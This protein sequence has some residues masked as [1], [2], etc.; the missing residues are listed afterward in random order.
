[1][2]RVVAGLHGTMRRVFGRSF[3]WTAQT[4]DMP[5]IGA[6]TVFRRGDRMEGGMLAMPEGAAG[7]TT[8]HWVPYVAV[9]DVD[10]SA[11]WV[12][13]AGGVVHCKPTDI[14][15]MGRFAVAADPHGASFAVFQ[16]A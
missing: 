11:G 15:G 3:I 10:A 4:D 6:Y 12:G 7:H 5:G 8:P 13:A 16:N 1:M 2:T 9:A 14:P